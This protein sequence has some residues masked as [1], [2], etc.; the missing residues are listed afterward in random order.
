[1]FEPI[2]I[3]F[4]SWGFF[5]GV[6]FD[7][8]FNFCITYSSS[9]FLLV[10][11]T[12]FYIFLGIYFISIFKYFNIYL[13]IVVLFKSL[14]SV[15]ISSFSFCVFFAHSLLSFFC[16]VQSL[17]IEVI[18]SDNQLSVCCSCLLL[19]W[20]LLILFSA[21]PAPVFIFLSFVFPWAFSVALFKLL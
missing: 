5:R 3:A 16:L 18:F 6:L 13:F 4:W 11:V 14:V 19:L 12:I 10:T 20:R 15:V 7:Y 21:S 8:Y 2:S 1:M 9:L 17:L